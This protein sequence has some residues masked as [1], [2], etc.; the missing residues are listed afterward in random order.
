MIE[1]CSDTMRYP[2]TLDRA[3]SERGTSVEP[4]SWIVGKLS[5]LAL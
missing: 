1:A 4:E 5:W 3:K 2:S